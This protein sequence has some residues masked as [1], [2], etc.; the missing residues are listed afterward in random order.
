MSE[1]QA[2]MPLNSP[3]AMG[4]TIDLLED[5]EVDLGEIIHNIQMKYA[6]M[7]MEQAIINGLAHTRTGELN[8]SYEI[9][10]LGEEVQ[11]VNTCPYFDIVE[12]RYGMLS[13][14]YEQFEGMMDAEID[15]AISGYY[16]GEE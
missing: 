10:D 7:I 11:V 3:E 12:S 9:E 1:I 16:E 4:D 8:N 13:S 5:T 2:E 6:Q 14:A 15:L